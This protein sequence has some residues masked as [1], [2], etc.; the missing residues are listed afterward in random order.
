MCTLRLCGRHSSVRI[1]NMLLQTLHTLCVALHQQSQLTSA[2]DSFLGANHNDLFWSVCLNP[3][4]YLQ[5]SQSRSPDDGFSSNSQNSQTYLPVTS[6][7]SGATNASCKAQSICDLLVPY[8][9]RDGSLSWLSR[10]ALLLLAASSTADEAAGY[11]MAHSSNFCEVYVHRLYFC[12]SGT[13]KCKRMYLC[14]QVLV[15]DMVLLFNDMPRKLVKESGA[16]QWPHLLQG[17]EANTMKNQ[18]VNKFLDHYEF[19]CSILDV[20]FSC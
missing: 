11:H 9:H 19:C 1:E 14:A 5:K 7:F 3:R 10:D 13:R 8:V 4:S 2:E 12:I 6:V 18:P 20:S 17:L 16:E 15:T